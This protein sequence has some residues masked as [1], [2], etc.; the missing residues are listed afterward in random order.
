MGEPGSGRLQAAGGGRRVDGRQSGSNRVSWAVRARVRGPL[1]CLIPEWRD[2][3]SFVCVRAGPLVEWQASP[4][5]RIAPPHA[6]HAAP[7][8]RRPTTRVFT[9]RTQI[10]NDG[11]A[12]D[13]QSKR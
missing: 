11:V 8:G 1:R 6:H 2:E 10:H 4:A 5:A 7:Q 12:N 13:S 3:E 9:T